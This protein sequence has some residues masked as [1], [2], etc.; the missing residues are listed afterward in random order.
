MKIRLV[1]EKKDRFVE[2]PLSVKMLRDVMDIIWYVNED[3]NMRLMKIDIAALVKKF[4]HIIYDI[5]DDGKVYIWDEKDGKFVFKE[6][7]DYIY[8]RPKWK[9]KA[10]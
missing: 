10:R 9:K 6:A 7:R 5:I 1:I 8:K 4:G 3:P 2:V